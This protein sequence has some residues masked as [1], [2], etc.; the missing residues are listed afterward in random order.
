MFL[1][2]DRQS[3]RMTMILTEDNNDSLILGFL[4]LPDEISSYDIVII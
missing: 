3:D 4:S 1:Q 2:T